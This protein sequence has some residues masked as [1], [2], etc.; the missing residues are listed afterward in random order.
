MEKAA[1]Y[2]AVL[3]ANRPT[4]HTLVKDLPWKEVPLMDRTA[5][6]PTAATRS[7]A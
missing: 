4:L 6:P 7:A 2:I 1:H 3:K 5:P